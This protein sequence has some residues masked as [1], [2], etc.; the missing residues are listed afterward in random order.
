MMNGMISAWWLKAQDYTTENRKKG[1][2]KLQVRNQKKNSVK[3]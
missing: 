3:T 1:K 2:E